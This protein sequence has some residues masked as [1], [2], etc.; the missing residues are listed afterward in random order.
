[1]EASFW[2]V[3]RRRRRP[4]SG[5]GP[6]RT[7]LGGRRRWASRTSHTPPSSPLARSL[8][9]APLTPKSNLEPDGGVLVWTIFLLKGPSMP[10]KQSSQCLPLKVMLAAVVST[11]FLMNFN[12]PF[13]HGDSC[14][15]HLRHFC[16]DGCKIRVA[17][18]VYRSETQRND[19]PPVTNPTMVS[20]MVFHCVSG[21]F[22]ISPPSTAFCG[23]PFRSFF[24]WTP[25]LFLVPSH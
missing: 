13:E 23:E 15:P 24:F 6:G 12:G 14:P 3:P 16:V 19:S 4:W 21:D 5:N 25:V 11:T 7:S 20:T 10:Q 17:K 2:H 9:W 18:S 8:E 1:M 22:W